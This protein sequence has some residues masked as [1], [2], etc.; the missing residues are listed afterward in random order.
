M[1]DE[2]NDNKSWVF[3]SHVKAIVDSQKKYGEKETYITETGAATVPGVTTG[4]DLRTHADYNTR[5]ITMGMASGASRIQMYSLIDTMSYTDGWDI[6]N[7]ENN[8]GILYSE[9]YY[10]VIKP[11]PAAVAFAQ[12][13]RKLESVIPIEKDYN[14]VDNFRPDCFVNTKYDGDNKT[15]TVRAFTINT[16]EHGS[17]IVAWSNANPLPNAINGQWSSR[18]PTLPWKNQWQKSEKV[19]FEA[20]EPIITVTDIMG[21]DTTYKASNGKVTIPFICKSCQCKT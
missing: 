21:N 4:L 11:K 13:S 19:T 8:F 14:A 3:E 7:S 5:M 10:G 18:V 6:D 17:V 2:F 15:N 12:W 20:T 9:D 1:P 16:K